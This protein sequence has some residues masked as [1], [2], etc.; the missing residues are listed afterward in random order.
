MSDKF[1][2]ITDENERI[3]LI[4]KDQRYSFLKFFLGTFVLGAVTAIVNWNIQ[5]RQVVQQQL[6]FENG[7]VERFLEQYIEGGNKEK[8]SFANFM[9]FVSVAEEQQERYEKLF[10]YLNRQILE[11]EQ[12]VDSTELIQSATLAKIDSIHEKS[13][14]LQAEAAAYDEDPVKTEMAQSR[15]ESYKEQERELKKKVRTLE[16]E[17]TELE[18]E[19]STPVEEM[20]VQQT[21]PSLGPELSDIEDPIVPVSEE[22]VESGW[23]IH[24]RWMQF[25]QVR[26]LVQT[27]LLKKQAASLVVYFV[28]ANGVKKQLVD[29]LL[30]AGNSMESSYK[31]PSTGKTYTIEVTLDDV[32]KFNA[33]LNQANFTVR[34]TID[35]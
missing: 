33:I 16:A 18:L 27:P 15:I 19:I 32:S 30:E 23:A 34:Q 17:K 14:A 4:E 29:Q 9:R 1:N 24:N 3:R 8:K 2:H 5:S 13:L 12:E 6:Q 10:S 22:F 35:S 11:L 25:G 7:Q 20:Q 28:Q 31:D 26:I 21:A